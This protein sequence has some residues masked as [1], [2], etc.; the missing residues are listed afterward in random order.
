MSFS[1]VVEWLREF[2]QAYYPLVV[3]ITS[4][5]GFLFGLRTGFWSR[6][7]GKIRDFWST[8]IRLLK[9]RNTELTGKLDRVRDAFDDDNNLWLRNPVTK[10][11]RY[12]ARLQN[13]IPILLFANL[14]G[15]VGKTT[16]AANLATYFERRKGERVLAI[17]LDHQGSLSSMLL[18]EEAQRTRRTADAVKALIGGSVNGA[19][20]LFS[21]RLHIRHSQRDSR[22]IECDDAFGNFETRLLLEWLI[23]D[24]QDDIR[25]NLFRV[26]HSPEVQQNFDRV[27]I[28]APPRMTTGLVNAMCASTHLVVPFVLDILSAE[29]VGLFL[30]TARR[31]R[32]QLFP[33]LELA[34]VVGTLKG[35]GSE[36]LRNTEQKAIS[37]AER[38][39]LSNWGAGHYVLTDVLIPRKQ[40]IADTAGIGIDLAVA[41]FFDPLGQRLFDLTTRNRPPGPGLRPTRRAQG[42]SYEGQLAARPTEQL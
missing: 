37:E 30:R 41:A 42:E 17:D 15:G 32:G 11:E 20:G 5:I 34:G 27:I 8:D 25:Y 13:S 2:A 29:R 40:P 36:R 22:L 39:V 33:H 6:V 12:D 7:F 3:L 14:K 38:G 4:V 35:D 9:S 28:D 10:P 19:A 31:M 21:E 16:I 1:Q 24:R 23:G 18:P 26:L